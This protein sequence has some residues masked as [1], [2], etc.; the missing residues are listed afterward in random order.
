MCR[1]VKQAIQEADNMETEKRVMKFGSERLI[2]LYKNSSLEDFQQECE[3]SFLDAAESYISLDLIYA[4]TPGRRDEDIPISKEI[5]EDDVYFEAKRDSEIKAFHSVDSLILNYDPSLHGSPLYMGVDIARHKDATSFFILGIKDGLKM[6]LLRVEM[7]NATFDSQKDVFKKL[8]RCLPIYRVCIDKT[9]IGEQFAEEMKKEFSEKVEP[10]GFT[11]QSK[12]VLAQDIK[13]GLERREFLLENDR[14]FHS[15]IH[16]I[17]R[18]ATSGGSFRYDAERNEKGH[19]DSFW[20]FALANYA[21]KEKPRSF[22]EERRRK[23]LLDSGMSPEEV[24]KE[25]QKPFVPRWKNI[26]Q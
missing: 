14:E 23:R 20:A 15:Q 4:N 21:A 3:C 8:M 25:L 16:S 7:R 9:G 1:D 17:K 5:E 13:T 19:A 2:S 6:S 26:K 10:Y 11:L 18:S 12:E 24:E 22:Y